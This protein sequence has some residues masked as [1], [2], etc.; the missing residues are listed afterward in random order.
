MVGSACLSENLL[1]VVL[2]AHV[3]NAVHTDHMLWS[4]DSYCQLLH[5][6]V[7]AESLCRKSKIKD[8]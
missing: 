6:C 7:N 2:R 8:H 1:T 4:A 5:T 3:M